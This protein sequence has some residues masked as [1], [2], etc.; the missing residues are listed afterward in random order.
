MT[1][2]TPSLRGDALADYLRQITAD[3]TVTAEVTL[4]GRVSVVTGPCWEQGSDL[5]FLLRDMLRDRDGNPGVYIT[6]LL[7]H[8]PKAVV[9]PTRLH[10]VVR[11]NGAPEDSMGAGDGHW[12]AT[13]LTRPTLWPWD[14]Y[15]NGDIAATATDEQIA[16][17]YAETLFE[18]IGEPDE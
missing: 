14:V 16:A 12:T 13:R 6:A 17:V 3:D 8:E 2:F 1:E 18:G 11:L 5:Y 9:L 7:A 15:R 10:A 4:N